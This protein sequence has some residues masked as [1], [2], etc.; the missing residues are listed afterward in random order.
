MNARSLLI[1]TKVLKC[2]FPVRKIKFI[3]KKTNNVI[4]VQQKHQY[5]MVNNA[6]PVH[7]HHILTLIRENVLNAKKVRYLI[8]KR[9]HVNA[10]KLPFGMVKT[11]LNAFIQCI[12][13]LDCW[14]A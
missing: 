7:K 12:L 13:I 10:L 5:L 1:L 14:S 8:P 2:V 6:Q 11:V 4:N 3:Q 9:I